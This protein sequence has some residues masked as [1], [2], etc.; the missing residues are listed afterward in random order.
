M[1]AA[2][3][4][5]MKA[6]QAEHFDRSG[7]AGQDLC[8]GSKLG[9]LYCIQNLMAQ[10]LCKRCAYLMCAMIIVLMWADVA[11]IREPNHEISN[12]PNA[13]VY[14]QQLDEIACM[15]HIEKLCAFMQFVA[16][17]CACMSVLVMFWSQ[18][19]AKGQE[20]SRDLSDAM[21]PSV[22]CAKQQSLSSCRVRDVCGG[23]PESNNL[24][25]VGTKLWVDK[26]L[27]GLRARHLAPP[28]A[29][30]RMLL[31][32]EATQKRLD[33]AKNLQQQLDILCG[34]AFKAKLGWQ[35]SDAVVSSVPKELLPRTPHISTWRLRA[36]DFKQVQPAKESNEFSVLKSDGRVDALRAE[37]AGDHVA[38][39][40]S[41]VP[42]AY[43]VDDAVAVQVMKSVPSHAPPPGLFSL[44]S[45]APT[46]RSDA[47]PIEAVVIHPDDS[48]H[49]TKLYI[50]NLGVDRLVKVDP[51]AVQLLS[52]ETVEVLIEWWL[53]LSEGSH[54]SAFQQCSS[55]LSAEK[56]KGTGKGKGKHHTSGK[57]GKGKPS[58]IH[59]VALISRTLAKMLEAGGSGSLSD[60]KWYQHQIFPDVIRA[61]VRVS[62]TIA[63]KWM[64]QG[65]GQLALTCREV[66]DFPEISDLRR[67]WIPAHSELLQHAPAQIPR[68]VTLALAGCGCMTALIR[69]SQRW[70]VRVPSS[71]EEKVK[72]ILRPNS[73]HV[74]SNHRQYAIQNVPRH[75]DPE[76]IVKTIAVEQFKPY[77]VACVRNGSAKR[78]IIAA[79][80]PPPDIV[81]LV[82]DDRGQSITLLLELLAEKHPAQVRSSS[83]GLAADA[84][85]SPKRKAR[86]EASMPDTSGGAYV[87]AN[88]FSLLSED[89]DQEFPPLPVPG[90]VVSRAQPVG[91]YSHD[92]WR[93]VPSPPSP[94]ALYLKNK[95]NTCYVAAA[96]NIIRQ[97]VSMCTNTRQKFETLANLVT[98]APADTSFAQLMLANTAQGAAEAWDHFCMVSG[99]GGPRATQEDVALYITDLQQRFDFLAEVFQVAI[100]TH[101][102]CLGCENP[103]V[104]HDID[105]LC[106]FS[107]TAGMTL[108]DC[109][110]VGQVGTL[111]ER[112]CQCYAE[113]CEI[114]NVS[115]QPSAFLLVQCKRASSQHSKCQQTVEVPPSIMCHPA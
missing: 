63:T 108:V 51:N 60:C 59:N 80:N 114:M 40:W 33:S 14:T 54:A 1:K 72:A 111:L 7:V 35:K 98:A 34:A 38:Q 97:V 42:G 53:D 46:A 6:I 88:P 57:G 95:G 45:T 17:T 65:T 58:S 84:E 25:V 27:E 81:F 85:G 86:R 110:T 31:A 11:S 93:G 87:A 112:Q 3:M 24:P 76:C 78:V 101:T 37:C 96:C 71:A 99:L 61:C 92:I 30:L 77:V 5:A 49:L 36:K 8:L 22:R 18:R 50:T 67:V 100:S 4:K 21:M 74:P 104:V 115:V 9:N 70:G 20:A 106:R 109:L 52:V 68:G 43:L 2:P 79:A 39:M 44:L 102:C 55:E 75:L 12:L 64:K 107:A 16:S 56:G 28:L 73:V 89:A 47:T 91:A 23:G 15:C 105:G 29:Q 69:S 13:C 103:D 10:S 83:Q 41:R 32:N 62:K 90:S 94:E 66:H 19:M 48:V 82:Q 26:V 113:S